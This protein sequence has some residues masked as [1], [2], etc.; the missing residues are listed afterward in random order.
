[1]SMAAKWEY[2]FEAL[3]LDG[4][5]QS[6]EDRLNEV[7]WEGWEVVAL[8]PKVKGGESWTLAL[9]KRARAGGS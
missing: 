2:R 5:L 3:L 1:M 4:A 6:V 7:G 8:V 9:L